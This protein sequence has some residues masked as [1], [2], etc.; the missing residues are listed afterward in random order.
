MTSDIN[1]N[2]YIRQNFHQSLWDMKLLLVRD[3]YISGWL[4]KQIPSDITKTMKMAK[5][6]RE[7]LSSCEKLLADQFLNVSV[8]LQQVCLCQVENGD[9]V[10]GH[11]AVP[12]P[13]T[14]GTSSCCQAKQ[15]AGTAHT[16]WPFISRLSI[17][18]GSVTQNPLIFTIKPKQSSVFIVCKV[19]WWLTQNIAVRSRAIGWKPNFFFFF[20]FYSMGIWQVWVPHFARI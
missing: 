6:T 18:P 20:L 9:K 17:H 13:L 2:V 4:Q 1:M 11:A 7:K 10:K 15:G 8:L 5:N 16:Y 3:F 19:W 12:T 14:P